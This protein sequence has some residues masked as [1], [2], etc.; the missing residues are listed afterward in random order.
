M[1]GVKGIFN[2]LKP[3]HRL[4]LSRLDSENETPAEWSV[5]D[6]SSGETKLVEGDSS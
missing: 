4:P 1:E 5:D 2:M 6:A 3:N